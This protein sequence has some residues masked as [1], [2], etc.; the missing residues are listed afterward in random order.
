MHVKL[1]KM[2]KVGN[3]SNAE[4]RLSHERLMKALAEKN[5]SFNF[6]TSKYFQAYVTF[7]SKNYFSAPSRY[8]LISAL[9]RLCDPVNEAKL[10]QM[11]RSAFIG[12]CVD[13][14]TTTGR[15]VSAITAGT[16]GSSFYLNA[17][18]NLGS[19]TATASADAINQ[20]FMASMGV[21]DAATVR[22]LGKHPIFKGVC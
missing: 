18:E 12:G 11:N 7:I 10:Q 13:G 2:N 1:S 15:H 6:V 16:P 22:E 21:S 14:W 5:V 20:C 4:A 8:F 17:Y 9:E 3:V 19:D